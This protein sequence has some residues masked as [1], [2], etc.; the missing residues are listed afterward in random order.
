MRGLMDRKGG[1]EGGR[2]AKRGRE[3]ER[4][5]EGRKGKRYSLRSWLVNTG[6]HPQSN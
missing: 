6:S 2:E 5:G 1:S 4:E 3:G